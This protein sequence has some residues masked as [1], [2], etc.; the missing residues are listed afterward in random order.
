MANDTVQVHNA[1]N[2]EITIVTLTDEE[3]TKLDSER[4]AAIAAKAAA[5]LE[6]EQLRL[7]KISAYAKL[8]LTEEEIEALL[9]TP[10]PL[11]L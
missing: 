3:Q 10:K 11:H 7:T 2:G 4:E 8:G 5:K 9:P 6:Q 1:S